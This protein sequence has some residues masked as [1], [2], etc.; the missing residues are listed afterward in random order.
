MLD[1]RHPRIVAPVAV[2]RAKPEELVAA[3]LAAKPNA[4][5]HL[6][7]WRGVGLRR[8]HRNRQL[9]GRRSLR[10]PLSKGVLRAPGVLAVEEKALTVQAVGA[11][12]GLHVH[13]PAGG[14]LARGLHVSGNRF[15]L[16]DRRLADSERASAGPGLP[17][18]NR[19]NRPLARRTGAAKGQPFAGAIEGGFSGLLPAAQRGLAL[20]AC[21][22]CGRGRIQ[23]KLL[24]APPAHG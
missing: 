15:D 10:H 23:H 13:A 12:L 2:Q 22:S 4:P 3:K 5:N 19:F 20:A 8:K 17:H 7:V 18:A 24:P 21:L 14:A 16:A 6:V 11:A 1:G 9:R